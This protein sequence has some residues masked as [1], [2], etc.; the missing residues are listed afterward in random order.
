MLSKKYGW[1]TEGPSAQVEKHRDLHVVEEVAGVAG[2]RAANGVDGRG[3]RHRGHAGQRFDGAQGIAEGT[4]RGGQLP[5]AQ[6]DRGLVAGR[7]DHG[8]V[9]WE[10]SHRRFHPNDH[11]RGVGAGVVR[12]RPRF[13]AGRAHGDVAGPARN[14]QGEPALSSVSTVCAPVAP[15]T[16]FGLRA[17]DHASLLPERGRRGPCAATSGAKVDKVAPRL[18]EAS[19]A[20]PASPAAASASSAAGAR[21]SATAASGASPAATPRSTSRAVTA[22]PPPT[23]RRTRLEA[24]AAEQG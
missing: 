11:R 4:G 21:S 22:I 13:V 17:R 8:F 18:A 20:R 2:V 12:E 1:M 16:R 14:R 24:I 10:D 3:P 6:R 15:V 9:D 5:P 23:G 19:G 7:D